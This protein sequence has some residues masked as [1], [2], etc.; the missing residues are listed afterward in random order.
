MTT[1]M[2]PLAVYDV[3][4]DYWRNL[5]DDQ[6]EAVLDWARNEGIDLTHA[7]RI[8][9]HNIDALLARI[10]HHLRDADGNFVLD[11]SNYIKRT[12]PY[13]QLITTMPPIP[14]AQETSATCPN[15]DAYSNTI[16]AL[17]A[18]YEAETDEL[19][20]ADLSHQTRETLGLSIDHVLNDHLATEAGQ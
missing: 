14:P 5:P 10:T 18:D 1:D 6:R 4:D 19:R 17:A 8:E 20:R 16:K 13:D 3:R 7:V 2:Q 15:C 11:D 9:I 12:K